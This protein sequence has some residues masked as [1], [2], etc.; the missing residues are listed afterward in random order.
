M[1]GHPTMLILLA[2]L[3]WWNPVEGHSSG[4]PVQ[5][6]TNLSPD[7]NQHGAA[8]RTSAVPYEVDLSDLSDGNGSFSYVPRKVYQCK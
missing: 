6:C 3:P 8:P 5:A 4:A 1:T 7:A 2:A